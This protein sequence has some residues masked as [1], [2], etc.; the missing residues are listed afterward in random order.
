MSVVCNGEIYNH[1][2]L[3]LRSPLNNNFVKN[4]G[5]DCAAILHAFRLYSGNLR[6]CCAALD[7]VFAFAMTDDQFLY[8][9]RD[10]IGVRPLFYG[11]NNNGIQKK[12]FLNTILEFL[13]GS[14]IKSIEKLC[15]RVNFFPPGC[16]AQIP[17]FDSNSEN[18]Q[19]LP[20]Y[21]IPTGIARNVEMFDAQV[22]I[23]K[24]KKKYF[25]MLFVNYLLIPWKNV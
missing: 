6:K 1:E 9:G 3:K 15:D 17:L 14:E 12:T 21:N 10:P 25:R 16:C 19:I 20:Y 8:I 18:L 5:S 22:I 2:E 13:I 23:L 7:G 24:Q 11:F 4:G